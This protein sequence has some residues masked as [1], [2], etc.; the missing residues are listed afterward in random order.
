MPHK[1]ARTIVRRVSS[2][3]REERNATRTRPGHVTGTFTLQRPNHVSPVNHISPVNPVNHVSH[4][5]HVNPMTRTSPPSHGKSP[6][7]AA[8]NAAIL[9]ADENLL[10]DCRTDRFRGSGRGGQ[11]RNVTES[12]VRLTHRP[13]GVVVECD[14]GRSQNRNRELAVRALRLRIALACRAHPPDT[15]LGPPPAAKKSPEF[16]LWL[17]RILDVLAACDWRVGDAARATGLSTGKLGRLL[18]E[19]PAVWQAVNT[20]RTRNGLPPLR[21]P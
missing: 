8:R 9:A 11:K 14:D 4:V 21:A 19:Q 6:D 12:A 10:R 16:V 20:E 15:P 2:S 17:A 5:N 7:R 13:T 18:A 1:Q 3:T